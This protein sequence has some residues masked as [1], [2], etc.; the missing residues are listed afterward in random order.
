VHPLYVPRFKGNNSRIAVTRW[1]SKLRD[2]QNQNDVLN[3]FITKVFKK[4]MRIL[5]PNDPISKSDIELVKPL[6]V[7]ELLT[8]QEH[9]SSSPIISGVRDSLGLVLVKV[10]CILL[11]CQLTIKKT[12]RYFLNN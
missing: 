12:K 1:W 7:Q 8:I 2:Y 9:L 5:G 6:V 11:M 4:N 10:A 3:W